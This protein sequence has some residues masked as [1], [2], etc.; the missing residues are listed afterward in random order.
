MQ[1]KAAVLPLQ[2]ITRN[3]GQSLVKNY[4]HLV[5]SIKYR[6][7]L[8]HPP[9]EDELHAHLA[10][11][12]KNLECPAI[13]VG[14]YTDHIHILCMLSKKI[15]LMKLMEVLKANSSKWIKTKGAAYE[16]FCWQNG[17]GAFSVNPAEID[18]SGKIHCKSA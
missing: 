1:N 5:F 7:P 13:K 9:V 6:E 16:N 18:V 8:I 14:G 3:I 2:Q 12:C 4:M 11:I 10:G 17:Y 15:A